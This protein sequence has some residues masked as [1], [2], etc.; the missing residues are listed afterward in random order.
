[1][2]IPSAIYIGYSQFSSEEIIA[3]IPDKDTPIVVYCSLGIRSEEIGEKLQKAGF[4][5]VKNLYGGIFE[6]KNKEYPLSN[7]QDKETDS[8]H[9]CTKNW[10][11]WLTKGIKVYE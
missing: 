7:L 5:N 3:S 6:W 2:K 1:S 10:S 4:T 11:K 8:V 9:T